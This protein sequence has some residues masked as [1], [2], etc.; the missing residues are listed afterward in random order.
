MGP[1]CDRGHSVCTNGPFATV[2]GAAFLRPQ[3]GV[4]TPRRRV[5]NRRGDSALVSMVRARRG[6]DL[7]ARR[8]A[9]DTLFTVH[10]LQS[11]WAAGQPRRFMTTSV[12]DLHPA[13]LPQ[14]LVGPRVARPTG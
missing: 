12:H 10:L 6:F 7:V 11:I 2:A 3:A 4:P 1:A 13:L 9:A 14:L 5:R 8:A